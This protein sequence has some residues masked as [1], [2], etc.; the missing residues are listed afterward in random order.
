[1][2]DGY[3]G[4]SE[5]LAGAA[6]RAF[7]LLL[8]AAE[9]QTADLDLPERDEL[10]AELAALL[11]EAS[12][13][14]AAPARPEGWPCLY[15][16]SLELPRTATEP[17]LFSVL[18][19]LASAGEVAGCHAGCHVE[20][21]GASAYLRLRFRVLSGLSS[22][23]LEDKLRAVVGAPPGLRLSAYP[24][25]AETCADGPEPVPGG[26]EA[27]PAPRRRLQALLPR[28]PWTGKKKKSLA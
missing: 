14:S 22:Q 17:N 15:E 23:D 5:R 11:R 21:D 27:R 20:R 10:L 4:P 28:R 3:I 12:P 9:R 2:R 25:F 13:P 6:A 18:E 19:V 24:V 26:E 7:E 8:D 1:M 16:V